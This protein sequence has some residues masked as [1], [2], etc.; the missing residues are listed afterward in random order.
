MLDD[1]TTPESFKIGEKFENY[2]REF[3][4]VEAYY[5]I[6]ERT[7]NYDTNRKDYVESSLKPD[8]K[9]RDKR[10]KRIFYVEAKF[11]TDYMDKIMWCNET[12]LARY[13]QYE[14]EAP[15][16]VLIGLGDAKYPDPLYLIPLSKIKYTGLFPSFVEKFKVEFDKPISSKTLWDR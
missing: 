1:L 2:V 8:F 11:R 9:F 12:Q 14:K 6:L 7:H 13:Q 3:A 15:V 16:F 5:D 10:T 4:F